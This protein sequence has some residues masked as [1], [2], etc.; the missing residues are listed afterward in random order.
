MSEAVPIHPVP[1]H[2]VKAGAEDSALGLV[3][4]LGGRKSRLGLAFAP[5]EHAASPPAEPAPEPSRRPDR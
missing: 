2:S 5:R 4:R 1:I 3:I